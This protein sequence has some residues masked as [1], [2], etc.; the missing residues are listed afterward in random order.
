MSAIDCIAAADGAVHPGQPQ[1][2]PGPCCIPASDARLSIS[3][4]AV[5]EN[6]SRCSSDSQ[7]LKTVRLIFRALF[8]EVEDFGGMM[9]FM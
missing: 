1:D 7:R 8:R 3:L 6:A 9:D 5:T 4:D 2:V